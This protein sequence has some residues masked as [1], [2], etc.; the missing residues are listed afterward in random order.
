[1][2]NYHIF[3][4]LVF[5]KDVHHMVY[6]YN[7]QNYKVNGSHAR[8]LPQFSSHVFCKDVQRTVNKY[9]TNRKSMLP[10]QPKL[11]GINQFGFCSIVELKCHFLNQ[12]N[13]IYI[14]NICSQSEL[15]NN[16]L[17][18]Y[19]FEFVPTLNVIQ[20]ILSL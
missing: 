20:Y 18:Y 16:M 19:E 11:L 2:P 8:S 14:F 6:K 10:M 13:S 1:M 5:C 17:Q 15:V 4:S 3:S 7:I 12:Y 9:I